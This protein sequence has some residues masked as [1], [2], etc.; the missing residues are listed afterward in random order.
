MV[1]DT[2]CH[3]E[4]KGGVME[5]QLLG[6]GLD[7]HDIGGKISPRDVDSVSDVDSD[8]SGP[9]SMRFEAVPTGTRTDVEHE[10][11]PQR[12]GIMRAQVFAEVPFPLGTQLAKVFPLVRKALAGKAA[13]LRFDI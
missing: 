3:D 10:P 13:Q 2:D 1:E 4:V 12:L 6:V 9:M 5:R 11:T 8:D 7:R